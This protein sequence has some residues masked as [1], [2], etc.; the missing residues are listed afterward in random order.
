M[1]DSGRSPGPRIRIYIGRHLCTAPRPVKEADAL[2]AAGFSVSVHGLWLDPRLI[3]RDLLLLEDRPWTFS[4]FA[5][6]QPGSLF[7]QLRW[8]RLRFSRRLAVELWKHGKRVTPDLYGYGTRALIRFAFGHPAD[9]SIFHHEGGLLAARILR[10]RGLRVGVDF[11]DWF[12]RDLSPMEQTGRPLA[13][14]ASL[15]AE[16]LR[17]D[18]YI[19]AGSLAMSFGLA[20]AYATKTPQVIYNAFPL[21]EPSVACSRDRTDLH[22]ISLHWFSQTLGP[23]RGLE[24]VFDA[25]PQLTF[26]WELHLRADD[27][28][29]YFSRLLHRLPE[30]LRP[31]VFLH[32]TV[33]NGELFSHIAQHDVGLAVDLPNCP[34]H[35]LTVA[36]KVFQ[37]FQAGLAVVATNTAGH[38]EIQQQ[39][40]DAMAPLA[41]NSS[42]SLADCLNHLCSDPAR[43]ARA[44]EA[45]HRAH[46]SLFAQ[47]HQAG[48]Y[49]ALA[50]QALGLTR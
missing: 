30:P 11:E 5:D 2:A 32:E 13:A 4:P 40:P 14:L 36:N 50:N 39:A 15:E 33:P 34:N 6:G 31:L 29:C 41:D 8:L 22:R 21:Q 18:A 45:S 38:R 17:N 49:A 3:A 7:S 20:S 24:P 28:A 42:G 10:Q 44:R 46:V 25:L 26:P 1:N 37:Y 43:L 48:K 16:A 9:L 19:T 27:P 12:S 23:E 47:E 35:D